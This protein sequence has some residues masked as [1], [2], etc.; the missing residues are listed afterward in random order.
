MQTVVFKI[1]VILKFAPFFLKNCYDLVQLL[2]W[3]FI[4]NLFAYLHILYSASIGLYANCILAITRHG[5]F[6]FDFF[7]KRNFENHKFFTKFA[8]FIQKCLNY[9]EYMPN[10]FIFFF[11]RIKSHNY[12]ALLIPKNRYWY[13][14][15]PKFRHTKIF[16]KQCK[17]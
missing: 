12:S 15:I 13:I 6:I 17:S 8:Y 11:S 4:K 7:M 10:L 14:L 3:E 16:E 2:K 5:A 1:Y 9:M